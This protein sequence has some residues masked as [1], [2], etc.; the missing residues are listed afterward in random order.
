MDMKIK[1]LY[2]S[3][4]LLF[5]S[6]PLFCS[7]MPPGTL[8]YRTSRDGKM[9]GYSQDPLVF[10]EKGIVKD[11]Y[12]GH[13]AIYIGRENGIDYIVEAMGS[14]IIKT[15]AKYFVNR[16]ENETFLGARI[17]RKATEL[18]RAK[19][20]AIAK[21][22]VG[23]DLAYDF[24][25]KDQ[26]GPASGE[27]TCVG[28]TE[29]VY[30]SSNIS[31]PNNLDA[32]E[33]DPSYY[34]VDITPDGFAPCSAP[35]IYGDCFSRD[36]EFSKIAPRRDLLIPA[37]EIFGYDVGREHDG[38]RYM[39]L[40][41]TQFLQP[42]LEAVAADVEIFSSFSGSDI[43]GTID[44][45]ALVLRWSLINNPLSSLKHIS[46]SVKDSVARMINEGK[47]IAANIGTKIFG[48]NGDGGIVLNAGDLPPRQAQSAQKTA[49][50]KTSSAK[51]KSPKSTASKISVASA[52]SVTV[53]KAGVAPS[54]SHQDNAGQGDAI[55]KNV[56]GKTDSS[57]RSS[58][59]LSRPQDIAAAASGNK[60]ATENKPADSQASPPAYYPP[61]VYNNF[62]APASSGA[63]NSAA[64]DQPKI[65][66]LNKIYATLDND[67]IELFNPGDNDF[68]LAAAGYRLERAKTAE[69]PTLLMRLG[70]PADGSYPGGTIIKAHSYYLIVRATADAYYQAK[71]DAIAT[72]TEFAWTGSGYTFYLGK[73]AI[74]SS[75]DPDI[76]D[77][78]GFGPDA[79][80]FL[81]SGPAPAISDNYFLDRKDNSENNQLD[82]RLLP[83]A[84]PSAVAARAALISENASSTM[85]IIGSDEATTTEEIAT[86][87]EEAA[88]TTEEIAT[89]SD[90]VATTTEETITEEIGTSTEEVATSTGE[91]ATSTEE[92]A[93][94]SPSILALI[95]KIYATGD[96]DWLEINNPTDYDLDLSAFDFHLSKTKTAEEPSLMMRFGN[97]NDGSYPGG[98]VVKAHGNYLVVRDEANNYFQDQA[99]AIATRPEFVWADSGYTFY[100][101]KGAIS[102]STDPDI[103]D[104]VGFGP[105]ATYFLGSGPAPAI[106]D[107]YF[108]NR[109][110]FNNDNQSDFD[111][112]LSDD[113]NIA[114]SSEPV[115]DMNLDLFVPPDPIISS[116][117]AGLWHFSECYGEGEWAVGKWDCSRVVGPAA[118]RFSDP[119]NPPSDLNSFSLSFYYKKSLNFPRVISSLSNAD[120]DEMRL[121]LE[122]GMMTIEGLPNSDW[123]YYK[124]TKFDGNWHQVS[125]VISQALDYWE[126]YIDGQKVVHEDFLAYLPLMDSWEIYGDCDPVLID[127]AAIWDRPLSAGE[128]LA[129]YLREAPYSP[130][131]GR[132]PQQPA[133]LIHFWD[134][135]EDAGGMAMDS[136]SNVALNIMPEAW[137]GRSHGNY[138]IQT[139]NGHDFTSNLDEIKSR[140]ISLAFW[141]HNSAY[142]GEGRANI[143]LDGTTAGGANPFALLANSYRPGF[144]FNGNYGILAEGIDKAI[145][146]DSA[147]H[148]L[149]L[150]YDSYRYKLRFYV[151]G[152]EKASSSLIWIKEGNNINYLKI[153][154][155]NASSEIDDLGIYEGALSPAQVEEIYLQTK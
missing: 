12:A 35:D 77:A 147:W 18:Q 92:T 155:D 17:P 69:D 108:L 4:C 36:Q 110:G 78:V 25:F 97:P 65:A 83:S 53:K 101:G 118:G 132:E 64:D 134:F 49:A 150:V 41:Y 63:S 31:N 72:R 76:V 148:H 20:V 16:A 24:D 50:A 103:V 15:P 6:L 67:F 70:N 75:T 128:I 29:K 33:Y 129:N 37:P 105:D 56:A 107:N 58:S 5:F 61:V 99:D 146:N 136:I 82:F 98:T 130:L 23:R 66:I 71:A 11:I 127:E 106:S 95:N 68:D 113:P 59:V 121:I 43:R 91:I 85:E 116:G 27:W 32:L 131:T 139:I 89:T 34:A 57:K 109:I 117:L 88:T 119:L 102:S 87:T 21:S 135:S 40:P 138:A 115:V 51:I 2:S 42:S 44:K 19:A 22:L 8:L 122:P 47:E 79:T 154:T 62:T 14:G 30:E 10:S 81:G 48:G 93:T 94:S 84:D 26:K 125:L 39:F 52:P 13:A 126:V 1:I 54:K 86:T 80:Y 38:G 153:F 145:P 7:A 90:E 111:L 151:D 144:W 28:L 149:A 60:A 114:T 104:A 120:G 123:R 73:G 74:S 124:D 100:L 112:L 142:P 137:V 45:T 133:R 9:Y 143:Y 152:S 141:W 140:D 3:L 55:P 96:N 46:V